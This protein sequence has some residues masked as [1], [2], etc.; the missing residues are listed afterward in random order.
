MTA[1][2]RRF[3]PLLVALMVCTGVAVA[4]E[5]EPG[6]VNPLRLSYI[7]GGV[8]F[9]RYGADDWVDARVNTPLAAGD[10]LYVAA[11]SN[12]ELQL[13]D[14][15]FVRVDDNTEV[16]LVDQQ[17]DFLQLK[18]T[19]GRVSLDLRSLP[20]AGYT[21]ELD[22]PNAVFTIDHAGYYR[23]D[24]DNAVR[25]VSRRGGH[26]TVTPAGGEALGVA[27]SEEVVVQGGAP[28]VAQSYVAPELDAWDRWNYERSEDLL[29]AYSSRYLPGGVAGAY[30]LDHYG[31]WREVPDYG[32][33]WI[34]YG[35]AAD[36]TPYSS[37]HWIWD[38]YYG[39]TWV[40]DAPWGWAPFHY[41]R[42]V[43]VGGYW[44]WAPGRVVVVRPVYAPA[45][46]AFFSVSYGGIGWVALGWGEP[47]LPWW[48]PPHFI[49]RPWW[50]GWWGP[51][52][53][54]NVVVREHAD[55]DVRNIRYRN[56]RFD[57]AVHAIPSDHFG[58]GNVHDARLRVSRERD[59]TPLRGEI[60]VK[61]GP[62]S[63]VA[64]PVSAHRPPE[65]MLTRPVVA[66][67]APV[68][69]PLPWR[70]EAGTRP[71]EPA[72]PARITIQKPSRAFGE[73]P[74]PA[75]GAQTGPER[76]QP[77]QPPRFSER[78][79]ETAPRVAPPAIEK[80]LPITQPPPPRTTVVAPP[81]PRAV[82]EIH[83]GAPPAAPL[84]QREASRAP[85]AA[86]GKLPGRAAN[87]VY[88]GGGQGSSNQGSSN[89][90]PG[91]QR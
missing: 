38:P 21:I 23:V 11:D 34:P 30:D 55:I 72:V 19:A 22:T 6:A 41:G 16:A 48:G 84:G 28:A 17:P 64:G 75:A 81:E 31:S 57:H 53:V 60:P 71:P 56:A 27:P 37:G 83:R 85:P 43:Y 70:R 18:L 50:G 12:L 82:P 24:I 86:P 54:N 68:S 74:R 61:P 5:A 65:R 7:E 88:R 36:W 47:C 9:W 33:V 14:R 39:W 77:P 80:R 45:L 46:V 91:G 26:A 44:A 20:V 63:L 3:A 66:T 59:L 10:A 25:F 73:L 90:G 51:H 42:W 29:D 15:A 58:R 62:H 67:R 2:L 76:M 78:R 79:Y 8:S 1:S 35:V 49:G 52:V 4:D 69:P 32:P 89:A 87:R 13:A 40:D